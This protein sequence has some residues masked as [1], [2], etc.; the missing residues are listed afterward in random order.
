[1]T[2][3]PTYSN[4]FSFR[5]LTYSITFEELLF[6]DSY[7]TNIANSVYSFFQKNDRLKSMYTVSNLLV[8][9][10]LDRIDHIKNT[11]VLFSVAIFNTPYKSVVKNFTTAHCPCISC[12]INYLPTTLFDINLFNYFQQLKKESFE[13]QCF[14]LTVIEKIYETQAVHKI[15]FQRLHPELNNDAIHLFVHSAPT[16]KIKNI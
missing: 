16:E 15:L 8:H 10:L 14:L 2:L 12:K 7:V 9:F 13:F 5:L 4:I 3:T 1:M 11:I 6:F